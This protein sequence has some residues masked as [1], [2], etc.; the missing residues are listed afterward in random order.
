MPA[1]KGNKETAINVKQKDSV[2]KGMF[3]VSATMKISMEKQHSRPGQSQ[4]LQCARNMLLVNSPLSQ[5]HY[6]LP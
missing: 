3:A 2:R 5:C 4:S 6:V 1:L